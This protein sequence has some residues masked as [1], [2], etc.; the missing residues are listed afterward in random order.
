MKNQKNSLKVAFAG[1]GPYAE[2]IFESLI[3]NFK[4][5][6]LIVKSG[7]PKD[8]KIIQ[9]AEKH[10]IGIIQASNKDDFHASI[11]GFH[12]DTA[13]IVSFG[14][15]IGGNT[16][17]IPKHGFINVHY[18]LLPKYRGPSPVQSA[19]LNGD[20]LTGITFQIMHEK[21]D[22]GDVLYQEEVPVEP[23]DTT[24]T[25]AERMAK[26]SAEKLPKV[27]K[28]YV[29][30]SVT[31]QKQTGEPTY[32]RIIKKEDGHIDW[33][34][35]AE[36]IERMMR[37]YIPWPSAYTFWDGKMLKIHEAKVLDQ[38]SGKKPGTF[39]EVSDSGLDQND[40]QFGIQ[41]GQGILIIKKIQLEGKKPMTTADFVRGS[42][43]I[44][45]GVLE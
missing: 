9:V 27:I 16:L 26:L 18:S 35:P 28:N 13:V 23:N 14:I 42:R 21:I 41:T 38:S 1:S 17:D 34:Q 40:K 4:D 22:E 24:I 8:S 33:K 7:T 32:S 15:I 44:I 11:Q 37:A 6:T 31:P 20:K 39:L 36:N 3:K 12:P 19:I 5:I 25:L 30:G 2:P 43:N 45:G 29:S 10:K